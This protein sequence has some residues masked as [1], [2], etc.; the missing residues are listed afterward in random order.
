MKPKACDNGVVATARPRAMHTLTSWLRF[1][2]GPLQVCEPQQKQ[3]RPR[4]RQLLQ[5]FATGSG[6]SPDVRSQ[7][8]PEASLLYDEWGATF[9]HF[10]QRGSVRS[11]NPT[12]RRGDILRLSVYPRRSIDSCLKESQMTL[13]SSLALVAFN[14]FVCVKFFCHDATTT[15]VVHFSTPT[16]AGTLL[17]ITMETTTTTTNDEPKRVVEQPEAGSPPARTSV[18]GKR[19][20]ELHALVDTSG[21]L[22]HHAVS[23]SASATAATAAAP[24]TADPNFPQRGGAS[25]RPRYPAVQ[26]AL[27]A[28]DDRKRDRWKGKHHCLCQGVCRRR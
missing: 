25:K 24:A 21:N 19:S 5:I 27:A 18:R 7:C 22:D 16:M 23:A 9:N 10:L 13:Y 1:V 12:R 17:G 2:K 11:Q 26:V 20:R 8:E 4:R 6:P 14:L 28:P 15:V 3:Q